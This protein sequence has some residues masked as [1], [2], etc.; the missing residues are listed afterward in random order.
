MSALAK[1]LVELVVM[2]IGSKTLLGPFLFGRAFGVGFS[3]TSSSRSG[4][5]RLRDGRELVGAGAAFLA[6][7]FLGIGFL[8]ATFRGEAAFFVTILPFA[9]IFVLMAA[10]LDGGVPKASSLS[11]SSSRARFGLCLGA[12]LTLM[13]EVGAAIAT[14]SDACACCT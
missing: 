5:L 6:G 10:R 4:A 14:D 12:R 3:W 8:G 1:R 11:E 7:V 13:L 2:K 9:V